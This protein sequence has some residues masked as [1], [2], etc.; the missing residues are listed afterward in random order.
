M[1]LV[2]LLVALIDLGLC[3]SLEHR[4][5]LGLRGCFKG[6]IVCLLG[7]GWL[8]VLF[9][10]VDAIHDCEVESLEKIGMSGVDFIVG[11]RLGWESRFFYH[12]I[13]IIV[14]IKSQGGN[15]VHDLSIKN[16]I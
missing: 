11:E 10:F 15:K 16:L 4:S 7:F 1:G 9:F 8:Y 13:I 5:F 2:R 3:G 12:R 6:R 14:K